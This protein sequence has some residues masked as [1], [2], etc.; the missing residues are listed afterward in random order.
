[1]PP[2][3]K[4]LFAP[5][6]F[7]LSVNISATVCRGKTLSVLTGANKVAAGA[8]LAKCP[9]NLCVRPISVLRGAIARSRHSEVVHK[10]DPKQAIQSRHS[11]LKL[12]LRG[13]TYLFSSPAMPQRREAISFFDERLSFQVPFFMGQFKSGCNFHKKY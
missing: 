12:T 2:V 9:P 6:L 13:M 4:L 5:L 8:N 7:A 3:F 1:M 11:M 10:E